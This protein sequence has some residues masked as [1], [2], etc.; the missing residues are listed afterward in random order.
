MKLVLT[1]VEKPKPSSLITLVFIK[2]EWQK[3]NTARLHSLTVPYLPNS[4]HGLLALSMP[5]LSC[6]G[7]YAY[8]Q[9]VECEW[10]SLRKRASAI[11]VGG[12]TCLWGH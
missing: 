3:L 12:N 8:V 10:N 9:G 2:Q 1:P 5:L 6:A 7:E 4:Y 11:S